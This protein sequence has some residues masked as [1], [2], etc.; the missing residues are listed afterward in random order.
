MCNEGIDLATSI[1]VAEVFLSLGGI[2][3]VT[4][5]AIAGRSAENLQ[6]DWQMFAKTNPSSVSR[7]IELPKVNTYEQARNKALE[8]LGDQGPDSK[9]YVISLERSKGYG[10]I[11]SRQTADKKRGWRLDYDS[12]KGLHIN[13]IRCMC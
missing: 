4:G 8:I 3:A 12:E 9:P 10:E 7:E 5:S 11:G 1:I 2:G 13:I 6:K